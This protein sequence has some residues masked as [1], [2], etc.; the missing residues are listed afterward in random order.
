MQRFKP[1]V[2]IPEYTVHVEELDNQHQKL[3][4]ITNH[5]LALYEKGSDDL[6][7]SL[8]NLVEYLCSHIKS[9]NAVM[10]KS[11]YPGYAVQD[12]QHTEFIDKL[13]TFIKNYRNENEDLTL[14]ILTYLHQWIF[15]HTVNLDLKYG[16]H[17]LMQAGDKH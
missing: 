3:F 5:V 8:Q 12:K 11:R 4:D 2:W 7:Q 15:S 13:L 17:L 1:L 14:E 16:Q 9:E 10:L 6:Y